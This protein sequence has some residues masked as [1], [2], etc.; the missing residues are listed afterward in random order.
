MSSVRAGEEEPCFE[1][2]DYSHPVVVNI[3]STSFSSVSTGDE[4]ATE[5]TT[6]EAAKSPTTTTT[7]TTPP[8]PSSLLC[9]AVVIAVWYCLSNAIILSTKWIFKKYFPFPLTVTTYYNG[10]AA[11][12]AVLLTCHPKFRQEPL[13]RAQ[14][15]NY[16][17]PIGIMTAVEIACSNY[18]LEL[19]TVSFG[20]ILK[21]MGP[22]FTF[23]WCLVFG[24]ET[25]SIKIFACLFT[26]AFGIILASLGEGHEFEMWGFLLQLFATCLGGLRWATTH[27]LLMEDG[28]PGNHHMS[29]L[30]AM[31]YTSPTTSLCVM[32]VA[33]A[34][35]GHKAWNHELQNGLHDGLIVL[36]TLTISAS[37]VFLLIMSEYWLVGVTSSA[38][39]SVAGVFKELLTIF[40]G[41]ILF[42]DNVDFLNALGFSICQCGIVGYVFLR[43]D[44]SV[45]YT[46]VDA[47]HAQQ[48]QH[49]GQPQGLPEQLT[50]YGDQSNDGSEEHFVDEAE[51][52]EMPKIRHR[53]K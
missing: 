47:D 15:M 2:E 41:I 27:K 20:T 48:Q 39:L 35:E 18:A 40:F 6:A 51:N 37:L 42:G 33:L 9:T 10:L 7:T 28:Q 24:I 13:S 50:E 3:M 45:A 53:L 31:L 25:F 34:V 19:L 30:K 46:P 44:R 36:T 38:A 11:L 21:G 17:L 32:P 29:P 16:V 22:V 5:T 52:L 4:E 12:L 49:Q 23:S 8:P 43:Y 14:F 1:K 26:M